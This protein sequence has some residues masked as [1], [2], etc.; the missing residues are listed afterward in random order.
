MHGLNGGVGTY[1]AYGAYK[2]SDTQIG[3]D[4]KTCCSVSVLKYRVHLLYSSFSLAFFIP[5]KCSTNKP[6]H[7]VSLRNKSLFQTHVICEH[8]HKIFK[9]KTFSTDGIS[10]S[11]QSFREEFLSFMAHKRHVLLCWRKSSTHLQNF[12]LCGTLKFSES[13]LTQYLLT[14]WQNSGDRGNERVT[15]HVTSPSQNNWWG[16]QNSNVTLSNKFIIALLLVH[17]NQYDNYL[18]P[19]FF[20]AV[21]PPCSPHTLCHAAA[22]LAD[23][24]WKKELGGLGEWEQVGVKTEEKERGQGST[25]AMRGGGLHIDMQSDRSIDRFFTPSEISVYVCVCAR[26]CVLNCQMSTYGL[27]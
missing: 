17:R 23:G 8:F 4:C 6:K 18:A 13:F 24:R 22:S 10:S 14:A 2:W 19:P 21:Y 20:K 9:G 1:S 3:C 15:D 12:K 5:L 11:I 26:V 27:T 7:I 25:G 16:E